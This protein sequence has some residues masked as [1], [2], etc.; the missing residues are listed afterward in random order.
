MSAIAIIMAR[1]GSKRIPRKNIRTFCGRPMVTW[2]IVYAQDSNLFKEIIISSDDEEIVAVAQKAGAS[3]HAL[4]PANISNDYATTADVMNYELSE[5]KSRLGALPTFCCCLYGTSALASAELL[6]QGLSEL[7]RRGAELLMAVLP[8]AHPI[9]RAL[10]FDPQGLIC[11]RQPECALTR[12][13]DIAPSYHD[14][15]LLYW[16]RPDIFFSYG[17]KDFAPMRKT[18]FVLPSRSVVDID[19]EEDWEFAERIVQYRSL[20]GNTLLY[21]DRKK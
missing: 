15:G 5:Y 6:K 14:T 10:Q 12:T 13:Q 19:T 20:L 4:R 17:G 21:G 18:A 16:F 2:P 1:G 11:Y 9:E 8:Y 3:C 7:Q